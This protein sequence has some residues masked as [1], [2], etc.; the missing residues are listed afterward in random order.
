VPADGYCLLVQVTS[1]EDALQG[2]IH[3]RHDTKRRQ[4]K[5]IKD[6]GVTL[7]DWWKLTRRYGIASLMS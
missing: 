1:L 2:N 4:S 5:R 7:L 3:A 6:L